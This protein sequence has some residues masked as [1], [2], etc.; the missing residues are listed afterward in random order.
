MLK[1]DVVVIGAGPCG[2]FQVFE[3]GL[4][5]MRTH[6]IDSLDRAGGQCMELYPNKP[7]YD[8]PAFPAVAA[9]E[10]V[11]RLLQ[12]IAP[13]KPCFH[14]GQQVA[15]V[16]SLEQGSIFRVTTDHGLVIEAFAVV[17]ATG[18]GSFQPVKLK[19]A[20][21]DRFEDQS[22]FYRVR[23]PAV[24][25]GKDLV[26]LGGGDT[27]LDWVI[28]LQRVAR[29]I[30]LIHRSDRFR[31]A[32][33]SVAKMHRLCEALQMQFIQGA[34]TDFE[35]DNDGRLHTLK[36]TAG[37]GVTRRLDLDQLLVFF[38][39]S[40]KLGPIA[41]WGLAM[42]KH[43]ILVDTAKFQSSVSGIFAVGDC[44]DY[45]GKKNLILSGFHE[46]AL[47]AFAIK[48]RLSPDKK[49]Y[50]QYTTT[51]HVMHERL[52]VSSPYIMDEVH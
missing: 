35:I 26:I 44:N 46:A 43:Q 29:S 49:I 1:T 40:P 27:A 12:Q 48:E 17:I 34:V 25:A 6:V 31:A 24:H 22:L 11:S 7:I 47:A 50:L 45:P 51:N 14:Y 18:A 23:D 36:V 41:S 19:V 52:G 33:S 32:P 4:Q 8:I 10:L 38:G 42:H 9:D 30:T 2:L 5:G 15:E 13:F 39:L 20:N 21:I 3:L 28:E 37:D 16:E